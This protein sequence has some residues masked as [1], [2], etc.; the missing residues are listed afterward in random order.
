M[1][2]VRAF[3]LAALLREISIICWRR[4]RV[5]DSKRRRA[6]IPRRRNRPRE[7]FAHIDKRSLHK[8]LLRRPRRRSLI[9]EV[10]KGRSKCQLGPGAGIRVRGVRVPGRRSKARRSGRTEVGG[11][12]E[13]RWGGC[14]RRRR[15]SWRVRHGVFEGGWEIREKGTTKPT[16]R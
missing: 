1:N 14:R 13:K 12:Q 9:Q 2:A 4:Q 15:G 6:H 8:T 11:G 5:C 3:R 7:V 16:V 10:V